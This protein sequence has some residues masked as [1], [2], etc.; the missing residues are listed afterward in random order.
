MR[1]LYL[2]FCVLLACWLLP[3]NSLGQDFEWVKKITP[4]PEWKRVKDRQY[5]NLTSAWADLVGTDTQGNVF[6]A[7]GVRDST[8]VNIDGTAP[9]YFPNSGFYVAKYDKL[10]QVIWARYIGGGS[11]NAERSGQLKG[12]SIDKMGNFFLTG[13][14]SDTS[15]TFKGIHKEVRLSNPDNFQ[16]GF[17][18][19]FDN[20]G[21][22]L[23]GKSFKHS[24][25]PGTALATD[26]NGNVCVVGSFPQNGVSFDE[27]NSIPFRWNTNNFYL[28]KYNTTGKLLWFRTGTGTI[29]DYRFV[30]MDTPGNVY[31]GGSFYNQ[32]TFEQDNQELVLKT[33]TIT[34]IFLAKYGLDGQLAWAKQIGSGGKPQTN[35]NTNWAICSGI[36]TDL[37]GSAVY[38]S[39]YHTD[40]VTFEAGKLNQM[41]LPAK[42][43]FVARF[44]QDGN[45][46]WLKGFDA[47][48]NDFGPKITSDGQT[49]L[50]LTGPYHKHIT[51]N[52]GLDDELTLNSEQTK[53]YHSFIA[54]FN[55]NGNFG[56]AVVAK[57][58]SGVYIRD[59]TA[60]GG[61]IYAVGEYHG[62]SQFGNINVEP[63]P[64]PSGV[65]ISQNNVVLDVAEIGF[66]YTNNMIRGN[67]YEDENGDG[68]KDVS[69]KPLGN[70]IIKAEPGPYYTST[71]SLGNYI[72]YVDK[73]N[74]TVSQ[75]LP[76]DGKSI[77]IKQ[78]YPQLPDTYQL[79]FNHTGQ[80]TT[81]FDFG[82]QVTKVPSLRVEVAT[83]RRRRCFRSNTTVHYRND[84]YM[85]ASNVQ[86][87]VT[88]PKYVIPLSSS[89]AWSSQK[90]SLL[91]FDIGTLQPGQQGTITLID[92]VFCGN[93]AIRGLTQCVKAIITPKNGSPTPDPRWD[94]SDLELKALCKDNGFV[95]LTLLNSGTGAMA[96][97]AFYRIYLDAVKVFESKYKLASK[98][99]LTL[100][101][102]VNGKTIRLEADLRPYHPNSNRRPSIT[103]EGCG[104]ADKVNISKGF[105]NQLPPDDMP[106]ETALSCLEILDSYDPN[107][108]QVSPQ[109]VGQNHIIA[110]GQTLEYLIRFQN[111]GTDV[112]YTVTIQDTLDEHLDIATLQIGA[113][114]HPFSWRVSGKGKPFIT[115]NFKD[116]N[117]PDSSS[118]EHQSHG[119]VRFRIS[120]KPETEL[121]TTIT[122][123]AAITFD[124]NSPVLTNLTVNTVGDIPQALSSVPVDV[125]QGNYPT[126]AYAGED[127]L[128]QTIGTT[129]LQANAPQKGRGRW[130]LISGKGTIADPAN[131]QS[132]VTNLGAEKNI[133]EWTITLCDSISRSRVTVE[134]VIPLPEI[135]Y[136]TVIVCVG[137]TISLLASGTNLIWYADEQ[138]TRKL[139]QGSNL[140]PATGGDFYV[141]Q[142]IDGYESQPA[143]V[144]A[145]VQSRP[146][147]P[148]VTGPAR[149]YCQGEKIEPLQANGEGI[150]WYADSRLM[151]LLSTGAAFQ[152]AITTSATFYATQTVAG[153]QGEAISVQVIIQP[154][155][156]SLQMKGDTLIAPL[157][158]AYQWYFE[159]Q[160]LTNATAQWLLA[161]N[162]G[163]YHVELKKES[164]M[165]SSDSVYLSIHIPAG[166]LKFAPNP[167]PDRVLVELVANATGRVEVR[168]LNTLGQ[169]VQQAI[170]QKPTTILNQELEIRHLARGVYLV[171][172]STSEGV[173]VKKLVKN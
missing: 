6:V 5:L 89:T 158:D 157:A 96:D 122:N 113:A 1:K 104:G 121:G 107:D 141:T 28:A 45:L 77:W 91:I 137:E 25:T 69:D 54:K 128:L 150:R 14:I 114:S 61:H 32:A 160:I 164:C 126:Q 83:D 140:H 34:N 138:L 37:S 59:L 168:L 170:W 58:D 43:V 98:D 173:L 10:G 8:K 86:V 22:L 111:T 148:V 29:G 149:L 132:M 124:F 143:K 23:W 52:K 131:P 80:D 12:L 92:S 95:R 31:L 50:Y 84:G 15:V 115:W 155:K 33:N 53:F 135:P 105:V 2:A 147:P 51:F 99:S 78:S 67:V 60:R 72:L 81:G 3:E 129:A 9:M 133:L 119:Y 97:S 93:E 42:Q 49:N 100:E 169:L 110:K 161:R 87:Q 46:V 74:F 71:D 103:L 120:Q 56:W 123:Q 151:Q 20:Q 85:A 166:T 172:V 24:H 127:I 48:S 145:R 88:Y 167:S 171:E 21:E 165:A 142:T 82:N 106:E 44:N 41:S 152:P 13:Y 70:I 35:G 65:Y 18:V 7:G 116:I 118:N 136:P 19:K 30:S 139:G 156:V 27:N 39:G 40:S 134:R 117:L 36:T 26:R 130:K 154:A 11:L 4:V 112:A 62:K 108:K 101:V 163:N 38:M 57:G 125:C 76:D 153:C 66:Q 75:Q 162:T 79:I 102:P 90:D 55:T 16:V 73:G 94:K 47:N 64:V 63:V 109:G 146:T 159:D 144:T 68:K 17:L